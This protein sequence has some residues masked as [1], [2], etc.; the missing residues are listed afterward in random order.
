MYILITISSSDCAHLH[1]ATV[2]L[3]FSASTSIMSKV[4]IDLLHKQCCRHLRWNQDDFPCD[5]TSLPKDVLCCRRSWMRLLAHWEAV[6]RYASS[7]RIMWTGVHFEQRATVLDRLR[8]SRAL[9]C[10]RTQ[11]SPTAP[12]SESQFR[13]NTNELTPAAW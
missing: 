3:S 7:A 4:S 13:H 6:P 1:S 11:H 9:I 10:A 5:R 2:L 8:H 12:P